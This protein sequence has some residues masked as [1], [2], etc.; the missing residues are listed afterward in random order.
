MC[1]KLCRRLQVLLGYKD[2][3]AQEIDVM[4]YERVFRVRRDVIVQYLIRVL[5]KSNPHTCIMCVSDHDP[6]GVFHAEY[7]HPSGKYLRTIKGIFF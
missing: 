1:K 7:Y 4:E 2:G 3:I 6:V 5:H